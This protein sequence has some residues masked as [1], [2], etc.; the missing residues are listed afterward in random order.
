MSVSVSLP[1]PDRWRWVL[2]PLAVAIA[3]RVFSLAVIGIQ[4][5]RGDS[6]AQVF[7]KSDAG[8]YL[9]IAADG[10]HADPL[11]FSPGG[12]PQHDFAFY[13]AWP[14]LL[15]VLPGPTEIAGAI[16]ANLLFL[17]AAVLVW[18]L[19]ADRFGR[20]DATVGTALLAFAPA[21][22]VFS[23]PYT[24]SL[25]V[26]L[27][28]ASFLLHRSLWR[29]PVGAATVLT[30]VAGGAIAASALLEAI[31][32]RGRERRAAIAAVVGAGLGLLAWLGYVAI[33][34]G[35]PLGYA[36]GTPN[37]MANGGFAGVVQAFTKPTVE[38]LTFLAAY[39]L[40]VVGAVL[41]VRRDREL[42]V[43]SLVAVALPMLPGGSLGSFPRYAL[44][45][46]PA[47]AMLAGRLGPRWGWAL[48][49][50]F[51]VLQAILAGWV[52]DGGFHP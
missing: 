22:Y 28:A 20:R 3:S 26:L 49:A 50:G 31:L 44:V 27:A 29:G 4:A 7:T 5:A 17:V 9:G 21:A 13:P 12:G 14:L 47:F 40:V 38:R 30:R 41:L 51:A 36:Q 35:D 34:T 2:V 1:V 15:R 24:E 39:G 16:L 43:Y 46:F 11:R 6:L 42:A 25:F 18:R 45:A 8:W 48:V 33:L 37:W 32:V 23:L 52:F 10:Y 19:F